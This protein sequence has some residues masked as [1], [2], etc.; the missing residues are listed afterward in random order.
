MSTHDG[1][2]RWSLYQSTTR[3]QQSAL[4][5]RLDVWF[6]FWNKTTCNHVLEFSTPQKPPSDSESLQKFIAWKLIKI[7]LEVTSF[8]K[9]WCMIKDLTQKIWENFRRNFWIN[10]EELPNH[11]VLKRFWITWW[12]LWCKR[13]ILG[14]SFLTFES[15]LHVHLLVNIQWSKKES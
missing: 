15:E 9:C 6:F 1:L 7:D 10:A 11:E 2:F 14:K 5:K 8:E 4:E 13:R 12:L 3:S